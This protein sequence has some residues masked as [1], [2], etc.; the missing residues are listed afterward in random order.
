MSLDHLSAQASTLG[1]NLQ[2]ILKPN[3]EIRNKLRSR[4]P[5][6]GISF[7]FGVIESLDLLSPERLVRLL[8]RSDW[9]FS[10]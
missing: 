3:I 9:R 4:S 7:Y 6:V 1:G 8:R 10:N 2:K 5:M